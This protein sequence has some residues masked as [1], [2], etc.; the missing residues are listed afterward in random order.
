MESCRENT[1]LL[2]QMIVDVQRSG[3]D[4]ATLNRVIA[5]LG[6]QWVTHKSKSYTM[7][8]HDKPFMCFKDFLHGN[9]KTIKLRVSLLPHHLFQRLRVPDTNAYV[10]HLLSQKSS[11]SKMAMLERTGCLFI[12]PEWRNIEFTDKSIHLI[13]KSTL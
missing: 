13:T 8:A 11:E 9:A 3:D 10:M 2:E 6:I 4:Q 12:K 1:A 7:H 5:S